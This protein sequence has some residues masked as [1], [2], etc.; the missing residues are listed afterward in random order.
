MGHGV[1]FFG[2]GFVKIYTKI[3]IGM[4]VGIVLGF[5][6]GPTSAFLTKDLIVVKDGAKLRFTKGPRGAELR[7][8]LPARE[9]AALTILEER[10]LGKETYYRVSTEVT[11]RQALKGGKNQEGRPLK[12]GSL[13]EAWVAAD[14]RD[15]RGHIIRVLP[16]A[17][18]SI[19]EIFVAVTFPVGQLFL[20]L[21]KMVIVPLVFASLLCGVASLGDIRKLGRLGAKTLG[22]FLLTTCLAISIGL[23]VANVVNPGGFITGKDRQRLERQFQADASAKTKKAAEQPSAVDNLLNIV[24]DNPVK[25]MANGKMLQIIFFA[26]FFGVALTLIPE[27]KS[28][29]ILGVVEAVNDTMVMCVHL[30]MKLAPYGVTALVAKVVGHAG[31]GVLKALGVYSLV[32]MGGL[33]IHAVA[34]YT[35]VVR[36]FG[37]IPMLDFWRAIRPAQ[38]IAF[39]TSSSSATLPVTMDCAEKNLGVSHQSVSFVLPLGATVNM[40]GTALY[41]GVAA[42][43]IAQVYGWDL[44][45]ADQLTIVGTATMA[46]IGAAGVPGVGMVTLAMVLTAICPP[47]QDPTVGVGLIMGVDRILDMFRTATNVTGDMSAT[48]LVAAT[49]GETLEYRPPATDES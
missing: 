21:I 24:P 38:L 20:R 46:S 4:A 12:T 25:S 23:A 26:L 43:F 18:S 14:Q 39:S 5:V 16:E 27:E 32:V 37:K 10:R 29:K 33:A 42:V 6:L 17:T 30:I 47:G 7:V 45:L 19:G 1:V 49:E 40:D 34:V 28:K 9:K 22:Y 3:F 35:S 13:I 2:R 11:E 41:Q 15:S 8:R 31:I 44:T 48:V 36:Y